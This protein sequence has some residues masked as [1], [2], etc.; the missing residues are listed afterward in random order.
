M[1]EE[2]KMWYFRTFGKKVTM[3]EI[4]KW[5]LEF[6]EN[7]H[8]DEVNRLDCRSIWVDPKGRSYRCNLMR[9]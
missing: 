1:K 8:G 7:V 6:V 5:N 4:M 9:V 3:K 2:I